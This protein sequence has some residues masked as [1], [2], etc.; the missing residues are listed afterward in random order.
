MEHEE[1]MPGDLVVMQ[2]VVG[3]VGDDDD[4]GG[5]GGDDDDDDDFVV[6]IVV[7]WLLCLR[8][9]WS[10]IVIL[11][12]FDPDMD[13]ALSCGLVAICSRAPISC[14]CSHWCLMVF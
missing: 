7:W 4:N 14:L 6:V 13:D 2:C 5:G 8:T 10:P 9:H 11:S 3:V 12:V 1:P